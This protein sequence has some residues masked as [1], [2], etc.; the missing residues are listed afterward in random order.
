LGPTERRTPLYVNRPPGDPRAQPGDRSA[1]RPRSAPFL[2]DVKQRRPS[3][4]WGRPCWAPARTIPLCPLP[5]RRLGPWAEAVRERLRAGRPNAPA[6]IRPHTSVSRQPAL[7]RAVPYRGDPR[8][9]GTPLT[10]AGPRIP[11][12]MVSVRALPLHSRRP[13]GPAASPRFWMPRRA[14]GGGVGGLARDYDR[15]SLSGLLPASRPGSGYC[16][17]SHGDTP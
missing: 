10:R 13:P 7:S 5:G 17:R 2:V 4:A 6:R 3:T 11:A 12:V 14:W 15:A 8:R 9:Y 16:G 1:G